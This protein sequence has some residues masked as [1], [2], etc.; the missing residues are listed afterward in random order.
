MLGGPLLGLG[1]PDLADVLHALEDVP[2]GVHTQGPAAGVVAE[3]VVLAVEVALN[4][5]IHMGQHRSLGHADHLAGR[6]GLFPP[7]HDVAACAAGEGV[8]FGQQKQVGATFQVDIRG[9]GQVDVDGG[10]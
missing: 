3:H 5:H 1:L 7:R 10:Q 4:A 6:V 9:Q 8:Q 2:G